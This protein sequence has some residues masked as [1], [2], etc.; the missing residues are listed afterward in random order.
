MR[1]GHR[2]IGVLL[3]AALLVVWALPLPNAAPAG[4]DATL[5]FVNGASFGGAIDLCANG[6]V[7]ATDVASRPIVVHLPAGTYDFA[8]AP[9][10][11]SPTC[12]GDAALPSASQVVVASGASLSLVTNH[13]PPF[14]YVFSNPTGPIAA[15]RGRVAIYHAVR[16]GPVEVLVDGKVAVDQIGQGEVKSID[17]PAGSHDLTGVAAGADLPDV[18]GL[19]GKVVAG[20]QLLQVFVTGG[21][22]NGGGP[23]QVAL[24]TSP[25]PI[26]EPST[27][28]PAT[29]SVAP[30]TRGA[31]TFTG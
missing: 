2:V 13:L 26:S 15:G 21:A 8:T 12:A 10:Q 19:T 14:I 25:L 24:T 6:T 23:F 7:V 11:A 5:V 18:F 31:A 9:H 1:R 30:A 28:T 4:Q 29:S 3:G 16:F 22:L 20:G 17:L 27:T